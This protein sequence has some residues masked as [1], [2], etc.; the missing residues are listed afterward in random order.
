MARG[1]AIFFTLN[2]LAVIV[3][4]GLR[5]TILARRKKA[6][7][8]KEMWYDGWVG[9]VWWICVLLFSGRNFARGWVNAGLVREMA[10]R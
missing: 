6:G 5:R 7:L 8:P 1:E 10:G 9:R 3:E 4:E 2:G